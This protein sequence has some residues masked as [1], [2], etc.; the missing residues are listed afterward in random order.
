MLKIKNQSTGVSPQAWTDPH[1]ITLP[2][3]SKQGNLCRRRSWGAALPPPSRPGPLVSLF[4]A[5]AAQPAQP[6]SALDVHPR[7][8]TPLS[9]WHSN[10]RGPLPPATAPGLKRLHL[11]ARPAPPRT[12]SVP[13]HNSRTSWEGHNSALGPVMPQITIARRDGSCSSGKGP[14]RRGDCW[15]QRSGYT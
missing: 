5:P 13:C 14:A 9:A 4:R 11:P 6:T 15:E 8:P 1:R 3:G 12:N 10:L 7:S 2:N